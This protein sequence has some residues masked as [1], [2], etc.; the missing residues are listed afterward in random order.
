MASRG[1]TVVPEEEVREEHQSSGSC[2][3]SEA[4][5]A[6]HDEG[7]MGGEA[8]IAPRSLPREFVFCNF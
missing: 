7:T 3:S 6:G 4:S 5:S 8:T 1:K 2:F